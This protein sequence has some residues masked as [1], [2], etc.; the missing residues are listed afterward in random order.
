MNSEAQEDRNRLYDILASLRNR[1]GEHRLGDCNAKLN[2]PYRGVYFFFEDGEYRIDS[3]VLR[4]VRVG[5]HALNKGSKSTLWGRLRNHRGSAKGGNH[6]GSV[7]RL[8]VGG[9]L[10]NQHQFSSPGAATWGV[11]NS[12]KRNV[13]RQERLIEQSVSSYVGQMKVLWVEV[14]DEPGPSSS[15]GYIEQ[16]AIRL[17]SRIGDARVLADPP[18]AGWLGQHCRA[19]HVRDSGLWNVRETEGAYDPAF[20]DLLASC[21]RVGTRT[22]A[23]ETI[24]LVSCANQKL[25][26]AAPAQDLYTSALFLKSRRFAE[27]HA[28]RW[29]VLSAKHGLVEPSR[30]IEPYDVTLKGRTAEERQAWSKTVIQ[31][32]KRAGIL[33]HGTTF[34]W[35]A[36]E[37]YQA[38]LRSKLDEYAQ[39]DPLRGMRIGE[40]LRRLA[41]GGATPI[42]MTIKDKRAHSARTKK[43]SSYDPLRDHLHESQMRR[44][45][46]TFEQI[47]CVLGRSL[48]ASARKYPAWWANQ[49]NDE[50]RSQC[51]AWREAGYS[52]SASLRAQRVV[53][54]RLR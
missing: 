18:S 1:I 24:A 9:A 8:H 16:H 30:I 37:A 38:I 53:F 52:A 13:R 36:G 42:S 19:K 15:R 33:H 43:S 47:E 26:H 28:Q 4:V 21:A 12:A 45:A 17:L 49:R 27:Q 2:W 29:Y 46:M 25:S 39:I 34:L 20:L 35:L 51:R 40:R 22:A 5:T 3:R 6:R 14:N 44:V 54:T 48:P 11:K 7:F 10:I 32:M 41:D 23:S 50:D 31:Q